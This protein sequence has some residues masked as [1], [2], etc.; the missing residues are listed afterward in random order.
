MLVGPI[1]VL[2]STSIAPLPSAFVLMVQMILM[3]KMH[4]FVATTYLMQTEAA[5]NGNSP[6]DDKTA[7]DSTQE[8]DEKPSASS[9]KRPANIQKPGGK[10]ASPTQAIRV[11]SP[12][13]SDRISLMHFLYFLAVPCL[14]YEPKYPRSKHV[15]WSYV[16]RKSVEVL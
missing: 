2:Y 16:G 3:L 9:S 7:D 4:S 15:R 6:S 10:K 5:N 14:V 13:V 1:I 8:R 11:T 12:P